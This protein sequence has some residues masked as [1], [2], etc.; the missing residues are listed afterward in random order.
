MHCVYLISL[1]KTQS[2]APTVFFCNWQLQPGCPDTQISS[3][4]LLYFLHRQLR[5]GQQ[6]VCIKEQGQQFVFEPLTP[7]M[8]FPHIFCLSLTFMYLTGKWLFEETS[9]IHWRRFLN[10]NNKRGVN[11]AFQIFHWDFWPKAWNHESLI[12]FFFFFLLC[13]HLWIS[14]HRLTAVMCIHAVWG[15]ASD[16]Q[17]LKGP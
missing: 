13:L 3:C 10:S 16:W 12:S 7:H 14:Q 15:A 1:P 9:A 5:A 17:L 6:R 2:T 4:V 11:K 8:N